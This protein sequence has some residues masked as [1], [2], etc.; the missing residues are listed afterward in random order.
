MKPGF[1]TAPFLSLSVPGR[2]PALA[3]HVLVAAAVLA[4]CL[5][6]PSSEQ[7]DG[8][9]ENAPAG[10]WIHRVTADGTREFAPAEDWTARYGPLP[11]GGVRPTGHWAYEPTLGAA[12]DGALFVHAWDYQAQVIRSQDNGLTWQDVAPTLAEQAFPPS[13]VDPFLHVDRDTGRVFV[14]ELQALACSSLSWSDDKGESWQVQPAACGNPFFHDHQNIWTARS[15]GSPTI[16]YANVVHYCSSGSASTTRCSHSLDGGLTWTPLNPLATNDP[17]ESDLDQICLTSSSAVGHGLGGPDGTSYVPYAGK[18]DGLPRVAITRDDGVTWS[19]VVVDDS[20][21]TRILPGNSCDRATGLGSDVYDHEV[22]VAVDDA[23]NV[24]VAWIAGKDLLPYVAVSR[25]GG[26]TWEDAVL[27]AP[28]GVETTSFATVAAG[29]EGRAVVA[30]YGTSSDRDYSDMGESDTWSG[31]LTLLM[32]PADNAPLLAT[33]AVNP[34]EDPIAVGSCSPDTRCPNDFGVA[35]FIDIIVDEAGRPWAAFVD[36]CQE[37]CAL[38]GL[39]PD[40]REGILGTMLQGP[41]LRGIGPLEI[42]VPHPPMGSWS[43]LAPSDT[44]ETTYS[45]GTL[46]WIGGAGQAGPDYV[47]HDNA[48]SVLLEVRWQSESAGIWVQLWCG[49][50]RCHNPGS[51]ADL[52]VGGLGTSIRTVTDDP[53]LLAPGH[54]MTELLANA[55]I[56]EPFEMALTVFYGEDPEGF[57]ALS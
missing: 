53:I 37:G 29:G 6:G 19:S 18:A 27:A 51:Q 12:P 1:K 21:P 48:T 16:G 54:Y 47:V 38:L 15:R 4:G 42:L 49:L 20:R 43:D 34:P 23:G 32:S 30:Y 56:D 55:A 17:R 46:N 8:D 45:N 28:P 13:S 24:Y 14:S 11:V 35:D 9:V 36:V 44:H 5:G 7:E 40:A 50:E 57:T 22:N 2:L 41:R 3:S 10:T 33:V 39:A 26:A 25:D 31:Y 52:P